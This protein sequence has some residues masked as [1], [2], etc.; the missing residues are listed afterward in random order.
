MA[1][2]WQEHDKIMARNMARSYGKNMTRSWHVLAGSCKD[3][4]GFRYKILA[5]S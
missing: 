3:L 5:R 1:K 4:A 2:S